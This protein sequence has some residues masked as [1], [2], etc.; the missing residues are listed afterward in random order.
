MRTYILLAILLTGFIALTHVLPNPN[1]SSLVEARNGIKNNGDLPYLQQ[2]LVGDMQEGCKNKPLDPSSGSNLRPAGEPDQCVP[3]NR[4]LHT[5]F[6][7]QWG[8]HKSAASKVKYHY[9]EQ[10]QDLAGGFE[11]PEGEKFSCHQMARVANGGD[12]AIFK[13]IKSLK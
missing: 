4:T 5:N 2:I 12:A 1:E 7:I 3:F 9:D 11:R 13:S 10:C 6:Q 8:A